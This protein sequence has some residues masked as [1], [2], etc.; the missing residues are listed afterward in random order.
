MK[1]LVIL[2]S[3]FSIGVFS[4]KTTNIYVLIDKQN[5][6]NLYAFEKLKNKAKI[7]ILHYEKRKEGFKTESKTKTKDDIIK[8]KSQP[9]AENYYEFNSIGCPKKFDNIEGLNIYSIEDVSKH[10]KKVW[11]KYPYTIFFL[12]KLKSGK[13]N[14]WK[15]KPIILE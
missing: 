10:N 6:G 11:H 4:Q 1:K 8:V 15:M 5:Y 7:K 14:L 13:Y 2:F 3:F 9:I 12:E